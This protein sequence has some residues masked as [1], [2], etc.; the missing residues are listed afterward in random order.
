M[1]KIYSKV[2]PEVLLHI[3][4]RSSEIDSVRVDLS[5]PE[6]YLQASCF[7]IEEGK[8]FKAHKHIPNPRSIPY[9][10]E[11]WIIITGSVKA[12]L[13]DIDGSLV[14]EVILK[15]GDCSITFR[16]GHNYVCM[17]NNTKVY[18]YKN[19][20]YIGKEQDKVPLFD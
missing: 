4:N 19:G 6:E 7:M 9:T 3:I 20:P 12:L 16:G 1:R 14:E 13:Y 2:N 17:E 11:S 10:Q 8:T 18:E 5:P 15:A